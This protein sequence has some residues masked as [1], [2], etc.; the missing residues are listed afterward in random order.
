[1]SDEVVQG[2]FSHEIGSG[3]IMRVSRPSC[4]I[5]L[6]IPADATP[7]RFIADD[8]VVAIAL[9][10]GGAGRAAPLRVHDTHV[11]LSTR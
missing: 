9:P 10:D 3:C 7:F 8:A 6:N 11:G 1:M 5:L 2:W 4:G